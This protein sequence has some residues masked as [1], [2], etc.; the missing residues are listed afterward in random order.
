[1]LFYRQLP[2]LSLILTLLCSGCQGD[3]GQEQVSTE[4]KLHDVKL[5]TEI[6][7]QSTDEEKFS[8]DMLARLR[9]EDPD[10]K[11]SARWKEFYDGQVMPAFREKYPS[12]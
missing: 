1:M 12:P 10:L 6:W 2:V 3:S 7:L 9:R 4:P 8:P 11:S 5:T